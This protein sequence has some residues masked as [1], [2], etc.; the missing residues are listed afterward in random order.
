MSVHIINMTLTETQ[1]SV[2]MRKC[3]KQTTRKLQKHIIPGHISL[4][5]SDLAEL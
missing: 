3:V 1:K 5:E 2:N 4:N